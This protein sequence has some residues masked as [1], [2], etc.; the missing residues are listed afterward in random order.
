[1][2]KTEAL[3]EAPLVRKTMLECTMFSRNR[4][5]PERSKI[6]QALFGHVSGVETFRP[7][8][9]EYVARERS[10]GDTVVSSGGLKH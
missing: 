9:S 10:A 4:I 2:G 5:D 6:P 8:D 3:K 7:F 1:M